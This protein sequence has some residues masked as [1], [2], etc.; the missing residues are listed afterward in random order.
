MS[1]TQYAIEV[2]SFINGLEVNFSPTTPAT[3]LIISAGSCSAK[4]FDGESICQLNLG[5]DLVLDATKNG[6]NGLDS[7]E[8]ADSAIYEVYIIGNPILN[9]AVATLLT[10][11]G[12][13]PLLPFGYNVFRKVGYAVTNIDG[14]FSNFYTYGSGS[15]RTYLYGA[16]QG[17][18]V[19]AGNAT[20]FTAIDISNFVPKIENLTVLVTT[21][22]TGGAA[23][24]TLDLQKFGND[25][26]LNMVRIASQVTS[27]PVHTP[28]FRIPNTVDASDADKC[29]IIYKVSNSGDAVLVSIAGFEFSV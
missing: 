8:L 4:T 14:V 10:L 13:T 7:G 21:V 22:F 26:S 16:P 27:V 20:T 11:Q 19:T 15:K 6:V 9:T 2:E 1:F 17:T 25:D 28:Q 5:N 29:K 3:S 24:R 12:S 18:S 23:S